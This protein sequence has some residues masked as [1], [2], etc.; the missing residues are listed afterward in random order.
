MLPPL[1]EVPE[2]E[3]VGCI[4]TQWTWVWANFGRQWRTGKPGVL[5]SLRSQR[6]G[7]VRAT[8]QNQTCCFNLA[9]HASGFIH[10]VLLEKGHSHS[11]AYH[12]FPSRMVA[13]VWP[14]NWK[15]LLSEAISGPNW[16]PQAQE[17]ASMTTCWL[18]NS[19]RLTAHHYPLCTH[20]PEGKAWGGQT[21]GLFHQRDSSF[22]CHSRKLG[23]L[24]SDL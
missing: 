14:T 13:T 6:F 21:Q 24:R 4:R 16:I 11:F 8:K 20:H 19:H 17:S 18:I 3:M 22:F 12:Y 10:K 9:G 5:Q 15:E 7:H 23:P 1:K 2:D